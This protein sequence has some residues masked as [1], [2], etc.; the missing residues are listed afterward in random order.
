MR[1][2]TRPRLC[3]CWMSGCPLV[4]C[5]AARLAFAPEEGMSASDGNPLFVKELTELFASEGRLG[6]EGLV[7]AGVPD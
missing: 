2:L 4:N 7:K 1:F 6:G 5:P 3:G